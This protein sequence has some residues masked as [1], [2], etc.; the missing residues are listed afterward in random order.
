MVEE[1]RMSM[2]EVETFKNDNSLESPSPEVQYE[3]DVI[4]EIEESDRNMQNVV[5]IVVTE[6]GSWTI[7]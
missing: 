7:S 6:F 2:R 4:E 1:S 5:E 3:E